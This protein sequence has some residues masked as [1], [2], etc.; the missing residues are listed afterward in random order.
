MVTIQVRESREDRL[1][2]LSERA[3]VLAFRAKG[4][5]HAACNACGDRLTAETF[6]VHYS[7]NEACGF[8]DCSGTYQAVRS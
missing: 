8:H 2:A 5:T 1:A 4:Y 7:P 3:H 6:A